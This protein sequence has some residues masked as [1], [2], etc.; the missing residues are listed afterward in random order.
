VDTVVPADIRA[1][2]EELAAVEGDAAALVAGL[3]AERAGWRLAPG[4]WSVAECLDHLAAANRVY[5]AA[6]GPPAARARERGRWRRGPA[7][8][9]LAGRWFVG[10]LEPPPR[11]LL[12]LPA[13]RQIR[14]RASP[15]IAA[16]HADFQA[17]HR[18]V[19][20]F[21]RDNADLDLAH[22]GFAN[23]FVPGVR[24]SLATGL[25]VIAAHERRHLWQAWRV[26][27][28]AGA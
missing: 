8:P 23:P 2:G 19:G 22:I 16:A 25:H 6:M 10:T 11:P 5:L 21:L 28:A 9:G 13:P 15:P 14:P 7:T 26:R 17:T 20:A 18:D 24:F 1:L 4:A 3:S 12:K 27:R